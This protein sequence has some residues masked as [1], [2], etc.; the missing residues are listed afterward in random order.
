MIFWF[1]DLL[2]HL[3]VH[4][5][6]AFG[7]TSTRMLLAAVTGLIFCIGLGHF[8]IRLLRHLQVGQTIRQQEC[9]PLGELHKK[10]KDTPT[11]GGVLILAAL[12]L[13]FFFWMRWDNAF[14][15]ILLLSTLMFGFLGAQ[16]DWL[17][18]RKRDTKGLSARQK[19]AMQ[20]LV[21]AAVASY[22]LMPDVHALVKTWTGL[23]LPTVRVD[24]QELVWPLF[25]QQLYVPFFKAPLFLHMGLGLT[26]LFI[27]FVIVGSS[28][29][30]NLTDGL[31]GLATGCV[32]LVAGPLAAVAFV[33]NHVEL[34]RYLQIPYIE[35]S[36]EIAVY[37]CALCGACL[38]FLWYNGHPAQIFMGD[39]GSLALGGLLG[40]AAVLLNRPLLLALLG[41]I[42]VAEALS[43]IL[44][45]L[46]YRL[47]NK[48]RIF[49][50][51]PLHHHFEYKG[52]PETRVVTRFWIIGILL[53]LLGVISLKMQ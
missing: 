25:A 47:R 26:F 46:S 10:K 40:V 29:A 32:I 49:L 17:K 18:V 45:V 16:D 42:F 15:W 24:G 53:A 52:W 13:A 36:S 43:V 11:M 37:L 50:C 28:N 2:R 4:V 39:V 7:Y 19:L 51:S 30:V 6:A 20:G 31:D 22:L 35:G 34:A 48:Q 9:P 8:F 33:S 44:Q 3:G 14:T 12:F 38:G 21:G 41:A 1:L 23:D 5:P 27:V